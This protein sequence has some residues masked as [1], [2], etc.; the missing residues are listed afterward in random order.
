[1]VED[2]IE[3]HTTKPCSYA[4]FGYTGCF[5]HFAKT[6]SVNGAPKG[7]SWQVYQQA[8]DEMNEQNPGKHIMADVEAIKVVPTDDTKTHPGGFRFRVKTFPREKVNFM[9]DGKQNVYPWNFEHIFVCER[10][11]KDFIQ[12]FRKPAANGHEVK[13]IYVAGNPKEEKKMAKNN[14]EKKQATNGSRTSNVSE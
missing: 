2:A 7:K 4:G 8:I 10:T 13:P 12:K 5:Y 1:M 9:L 6:Y 11:R 3:K 14:E